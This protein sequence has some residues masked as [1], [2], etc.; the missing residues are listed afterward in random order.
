MGEVNLAFLHQ[1]IRLAAIRHDPDKHSLRSKG[2]RDIVGLQAC[3]IGV[4]DAGGQHPHIAPFPVW[5]GA[6]NS[7]ALVRPIGKFDR[8]RLA[9]DAPNRLECVT[10]T[11]RHALESLAVVAPDWLLAH[12]QP[13][14]A[15]RYGHRAMDDRLAKNAAR[16]A[17]RARIVGQDGHALLAAALDPAAP[18]W[19]RQVPAVEI[20][21]RVWVQ[22]FYLSAEGVSGARPSTAS[23]RPR[24]F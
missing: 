10:E 9:P 2:A 12:A 13:D 8:L 20:L 11:M 6:A 17:E 14:W 24:C 19:L 16:R 3:H 7:D 5:S 4:T 22:Q 1:C 23:R 18:S 15:E 21:R